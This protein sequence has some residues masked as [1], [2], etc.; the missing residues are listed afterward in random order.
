MSSDPTHVAPWHAR[1]VGS[2]D[3]TPRRAGAAAAVLVAVPL[4]AGPERG[5][6]L[7][8]YVV[9]DPIG[10]GGMGT[11]VSAYDPE[12][13]RKVAIKL[14]HASDDHDGDGRLIR[15]ARALAKLRHPNVVAVHDVGE[16][17][18]GVYLAMELVEGVDLR[19]WIKTRPAWR[20]VTRVFLDAG[21][22]LAAAHAQGL[23]HRDFKPAN[24]VLG[25]DGRAR[26]LDFG[27][28]RSA[29]SFAGLG[30]GGPLDVV[31]TD[32]SVLGTPAY[33]APE[34]HD[35]RVIDARADQWA[36]CVAL[37]EALWGVRPFIGNDAA[38]IQAA[39]LR[40]Q[41]IATAPGN[42][43]P[44]LRRAVMR[45]LRP[46]PDARF[47]QMAE[48]LAIL[49]R[50]YS[51]RPRRIAAFVAAVVLGA[52]ASTAVFVLRDR[53]VEAHAWLDD[54]AAAARAA[55]AQAYFVYPPADDP[56]HETAIVHVLALERRGDPEA[57]I[58]A[59]SLRE[60]FAATLVR[61]GDRYWDVD[62]GRGFA[63][64][65]YVQALVFVA[66]PHA[67]ERATI[68]PGELVAL[69]QRADA[70]DFSTAEL[71][72]ARV[73]VILADP[74]DEARR[75]ALQRHR[76][77]AGGTTRAAALDALVP[78]QPIAPAVAPTI[79]S[80]A[81]TAPTDAP[82][83]AA[84][85][86]ATASA[87]SSASAI[88]AEAKTLAKSGDA[89]AAE[90]AYHRA[91]ASDPR[92]VGALAGLAELHFDR[93]AYPKAVS[94]GER[95]VAQAPTRAAL[96]IALGDALF[97]V[98]RYADARAQYERADALGHASA[99]ARLAQ[100]AAKLGK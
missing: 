25:K 39:A 82:P 40:G 20:E 96:R 51:R 81:A 32:G 28:A 67:R 53:Q 30:G 19:E 55:A 15:E 76:S 31:V 52:S 26:V 87:S 18:D 7:G 63:I 62:G 89:A 29:Q 73:L 27:L 78:P 98:S 91:L 17:G 48:L 77:R 50:L 93:A 100:L 42:V 75:T 23:V 79:P 4:R 5:T 41:P 83:P 58:L 38:Q 24:V 69:R 21:H 54:A 88:V 14:V 84:P 64:D 1:A 80:P 60:E 90:R 8:R 35:G 92:H 12:L 49:Q 33:M 99:K 57:D 72:A 11:V 6:S 71:D 10:E 61:L 9:L 59:A 74:D 66:D 44:M 85:R 37:H 56:E 3:A 45:G 36:F 86:A 22:G 97:K 13:D 34:Q 94:F 46:D 16:W 65:Y 70:R 43:P 68:T 2:S 47:A 95:A